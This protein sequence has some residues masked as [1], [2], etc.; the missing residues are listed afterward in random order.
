MSGQQ[1]YD[2][3]PTR[4]EPLGGSGQGLWI[5]I[6]L[7]NAMLS[8]YYGDGPRHNGLTPDQEHDPTRDVPLRDY[9]GTMKEPPP[10]GGP[11]VARLTTPFRGSWKPRG[12][13]EPR[14]PPAPTPEEDPSDERREAP[15]PADG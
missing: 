2:G 4:D 1:P 15:S 9:A 3:Q 13:N 7:A 12:I 14:T 5:P 11:P 6:G 8:C 10:S